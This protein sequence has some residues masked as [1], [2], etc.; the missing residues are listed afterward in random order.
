[1]IKRL[2]EGWRARRFASEREQLLDSENPVLAF[3]GDP[4]TGTQRLRPGE[5]NEH[6]YALLQRG[7]LRLTRVHDGREMPASGFDR[8][9]FVEPWDPLSASVIGSH[10][11]P[12]EGG[13]L[14]TFGIVFVSGARDDLAS[15]VEAAWYKPV[16]FVL[17]TADP[18]RAEIA[19]VPFAAVRGRD[20]SL[21]FGE[22]LDGSC[23]REPPR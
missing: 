23:F 17:S 15:R 5:T 2:L 14:G 13:R 11:R 10:R 21:T 12:F 9:V 8:L 3:A 1:M 16:A 6:A 4:K 18:L 20:G 22:G 19:I 7:A